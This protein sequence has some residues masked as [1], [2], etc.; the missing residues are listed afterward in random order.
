MT[1]TLIFQK[2]NIP[3]LGRGRL[4]GQTHTEAQVHGRVPLYLGCVCVCVL[5]LVCVCVCVPS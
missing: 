4:C 1:W 3:F 2:Q 5:Y